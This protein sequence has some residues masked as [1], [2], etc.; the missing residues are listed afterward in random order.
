MQ[1]MKWDQ[2]VLWIPKIEEIG[3]NKDKDANDTD[4]HISTKH[5][6]NA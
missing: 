5:K 4:I 2:I 3:H 6:K 1:H